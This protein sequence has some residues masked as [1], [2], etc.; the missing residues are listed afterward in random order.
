L[1]IWLSDLTPPPSLA[2]AL[3]KLILDYI[4]I[5]FHVDLNFTNLSDFCKDF[6]SSVEKGFFSNSGTTLSPGAMIL[7]NLILHNVR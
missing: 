5:S 1:Q 3:T 7:I 2:M 4:I 6:F